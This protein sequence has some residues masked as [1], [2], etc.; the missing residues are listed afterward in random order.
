[1]VPLF[2]RYFRS[3]FSGISTRFLRFFVNCMHT[4]HNVTHIKM[5]EIVRNIPCG[6]FGVMRPA[7]CAWAGSLQ[8]R[9]LAKVGYAYV[10]CTR[11]L[12]H[13]L[14]FIK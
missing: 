12:P 7:G 10:T 3:N 13:I 11:G 8:R 9:E 14:Y 2:G 6:D 4:V 1:M 5:A